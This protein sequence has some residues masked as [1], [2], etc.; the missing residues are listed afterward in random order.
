[1]LARALDH[2]GGFAGWAAPG[3]ALA[4]FRA[5]TAARGLPALAGFAEFDR[6]TGSVE[7]GTER[8][9]DEALLFAYACWM[10]RAEAIALPLEV[11]AEEL[12]YV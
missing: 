6:L 9:R 4:A 11:I 12:A 3:E 7:L 5:E 8:A 10:E 2:L 1:V